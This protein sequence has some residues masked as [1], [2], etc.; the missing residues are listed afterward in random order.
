MYDIEFTDGTKTLRGHEVTWETLPKNVEF[1]GGDIDEHYEGTKFIEV[2]TFNAVFMEDDFEHEKV[3]AL[4]NGMILTA[5][6]LE[7]KGFDWSL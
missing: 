3:F 7:E 2:G 4:T 1:M 6:E 5:G